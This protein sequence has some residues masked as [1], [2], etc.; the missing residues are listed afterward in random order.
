MISDADAAAL[1]D[2]LNPWDPGHRPEDRFYNELVMA[3]DSV[4]DVGCGT[5]AMLIR[6]RE[7][8]HHGRLVGLDPDR[9]ALARAQRRTDIDWIEGTAAQAD[10]VDRAGAGFELATMTGHAFQCL[11]TDDELRSSLAAIHASL[12]PGGRFAFETRHPRARAWE[13][14]N[15]SNVLDFEAFG[16]PLRLWHEVDSVTADVVTFDG[17][18]AT[19]DGTVLQADRTSLRFLDVAPLNAFL[20]AAG[21]EIE[22]QYGYWG[23][24]PVTGAGAREIIT[25]AR[26]VR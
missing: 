7:Q 6:A 11:L 2:L 1:Y 20:A 17:T 3:A 23:G 19:P 10:R 21:F 25:I 15:P 16:R 5:G 22:A 18:M 26:R 9:A 8:G 24:E 12:R 14:W 13:G 4:L